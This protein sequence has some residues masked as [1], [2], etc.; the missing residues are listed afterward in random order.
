MKNK[1]EDYTRKTTEEN[2]IYIIFEENRGKDSIFSNRWIYTAFKTV[3]TAVSVTLREVIKCLLNTNTAETIKCVPGELSL[4][5]I[6]NHNK[7]NMVLSFYLPQ[8]QEVALGVYNCMGTML[9]PVAD[10]YKERGTNRIESSA[11]RI[12]SGIFVCKLQ[13]MRSG[14]AAKK[15]VIVK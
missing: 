15:V 12:S 13:T 14:T 7:S 1:I 2:F 8:G 10:G 9:C 5:I 6:Q 11:K 3:M 4:E